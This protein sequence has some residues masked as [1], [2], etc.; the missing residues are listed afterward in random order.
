VQK[1]L[2]TT[3]A[4][5]QEITDLL[6]TVRDPLGGAKKKAKEFEEAVKHPDETLKKKAE[7]KAK[8]LTSTVGTAT[9]K[10]KKVLGF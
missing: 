10:A 7:T 6:A 3:Q 8:E 2:E 5:L 4:A 1:A 9:Q